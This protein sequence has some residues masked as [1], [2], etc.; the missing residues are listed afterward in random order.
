VTDRLTGW[1]RRPVSDRWWGGPTRGDVLLVAVVVA[2]GAT[3]I[4]AMA[5]VVWGG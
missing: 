4:V 1:L 5:A 2:I 3:A